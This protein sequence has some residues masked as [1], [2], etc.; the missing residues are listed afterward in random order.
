MFL[1]SALCHRVISVSIAL[2]IMNDRW[3]NV[4]LISIN[5]SNND[6]KLD[7]AVAPCITVIT[8]TVRPSGCK[9][10]HI[11]DQQFKLWLRA[12]Q[13]QNSISPKSFVR[14]VRADSAFFTLINT[15]AVRNAAHTSLMAEKLQTSTKKKEKEKTTTTAIEATTWKPHS[16]MCSEHFSC[17]KIVRGE[18]ISPSEGHCRPPVGPIAVCLP[19]KQVSWWCSETPSIETKFLVCQ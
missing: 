5:I 10:R 7:Y 1:L 13:E 6:L 8:L 2:K 17:F 18:E 14:A 11:I 12:Q 9:Q 19:G 16:L 4:K 3:T 15:A